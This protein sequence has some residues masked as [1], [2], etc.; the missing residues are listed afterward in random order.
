[1][2]RVGARRVRHQPI[3][4]NL[5]EAPSTIRKKEGS[6]KT[7]GDYTNARFKFRFQPDLSV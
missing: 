7:K 1:M 4:M 2:Q 5:R 3:I 6:F